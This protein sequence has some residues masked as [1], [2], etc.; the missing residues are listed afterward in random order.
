MFFVF[1][2]S[3]CLQVTENLKD[4]KPEN[5]QK[6]PVPYLHKAFMMSVGIRGSGDRSKRL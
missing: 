6:P 5:K 1:G 2:V 3:T 4:F